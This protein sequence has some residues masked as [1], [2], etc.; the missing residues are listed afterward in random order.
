[1]A[2]P[3]PL[4]NAT[5]VS[6]QDILQA[7]VDRLTDQLGNLLAV[8]FFPDR[9]EDY[10]LNHVD[11]ALLVSYGG[12]QFSAPPAS[13]LSAP[14]LPARSAP[15]KRTLKFVVTLLVRALNGDHGAAEMLDAARGA[16]RGF[17]PPGCARPLWFTQE[18]PLG[19]AGGVWQYA[20]ELATET[21]DGA[22]GPSR[23][24]TTPTQE[25]P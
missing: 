22:A 7:V 17:R 13:G 10:E 2:I 23:V 8:D 24:S 5:T 21:W 6:T 14:A 20:I 19:A 12:G 15:Q 9:P 11:G 4:Q 16:L 18:T 1:M 25:T 3:P